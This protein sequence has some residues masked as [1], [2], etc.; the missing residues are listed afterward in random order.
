[1]E[2]KS[3]YFQRVPR[4]LPSDQAAQAWHGF[5]GGPAALTLRRDDA[6]YRIHPR[7]GG[8]PEHPAVPDAVWRPSITMTDLLVGR[9]LASGGLLGF[10]DV[11]PGGL[12]EAGRS[13][14]IRRP[15]SGAAS[16]AKIK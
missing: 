8:D 9:E 14:I 3:F 13:P 12:H 1:M 5:R 2:V 6:D 7:D 16:S 10:A 4:L 15:D 11:R